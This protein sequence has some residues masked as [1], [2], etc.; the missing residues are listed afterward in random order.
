MQG[1]P[2]SDFFDLTPDLVW[3]MGKDGFL[4]KVNRAVIEKLEY[5]LKRNCIINH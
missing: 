4:K 2:I 3:I 5:I 1:F